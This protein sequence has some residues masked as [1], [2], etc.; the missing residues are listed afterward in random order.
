MLATPSAE[1]IGESEKVL[2]LDRAQHGDNRLLHDLV[3]QRCHA[4]RSL[5][6]IGF[7]DINPS[8]WLGAVRPGMDS[9]VQVFHPFEEDWLMLSPRHRL[10]PCVGGRRNCPP[11]ATA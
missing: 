2:F 4:E 8:R 9:L 1:A 10:P 6:T 7:R 3:L 11:T 5:P